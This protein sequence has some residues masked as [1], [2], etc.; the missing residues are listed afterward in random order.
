MDQL[1][2]IGNTYAGD[3]A[4]ILVI[5]VIFFL[6]IGFLFAREQSLRLIKG[7]FI[8]IAW[9]FASPFVYV[10][11]T[12]GE[13]AAI[14]SNPVHREA[15]NDQYLISRVLLILR[16]VVVVVAIAILAA[17]VAKGWEDFL[18]SKYLRMEET[19][20]QR[21]LDNIRK[22]QDS[23]R[24]TIAAEDKDW[25]AKKDGLMRQHQQNRSKKASDALVANRSLVIA[26]N[27]DQRDAQVLAAIQ[28]YF[29]SQP[30]GTPSAIA[31][32]AR[33]ADN[34]IAGSFPPSPDQLRQFVDNW[35]TAQLSTLPETSPEDAARAELQGDYAQNKANL[36]D[37]LQQETGTEQ[38]LTQVQQQEEYSPSSLLLDVVKGI[39][40]FIFFVWAL[41]LILEALLISIFIAHD[42]RLIRI[43]NE[44]PKREE[45][46]V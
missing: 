2:I 40:S 4:L 39:I 33:N 42:V 26:L 32:L 44:V 14:P 34:F 24:A 45:V 18:P 23:V 1:S 17:S 12:I 46:A 16:G 29:Q 31:N 28:N 7:L 41:G 27:A 11:K 5:F 25:A 38:Q 3:Y 35:A 10:R 13:L 6:A 30:H 19:A 36:A 9:I 22:Q 20:V 43:A 21:Q 15:G 8:N 37:L